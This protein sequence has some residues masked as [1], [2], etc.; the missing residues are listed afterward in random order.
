MSFLSYSVPQRP[1]PY[2]YGTQSIS[3]RTGELSLSGTLLVEDANHLDRT[4]RD[5]CAR[6][7]DR[8]YASLVEEVVVLS[9]NHTT[10]GNENVGAAKFLQFSDNLRD[11]GLVACCKRKIGRASCRERV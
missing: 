3:E 6:A 10:S 1:L 2:R 11:K 4:L 9:R 7:E 5:A 8:A